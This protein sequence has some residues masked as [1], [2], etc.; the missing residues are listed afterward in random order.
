MKLEEELARLNAVPLNHG[1]P[2]LSAPVDAAMDTASVE[3]AIAPFRLPSDLR[4]LWEQVDLEQIPNAP[5]RIAG[6]PGGESVK[7]QDESGEMQVWCPAATQ[8]SI[9]EQLE[10]DLTLRAIADVASD[11]DRKTLERIEDNLT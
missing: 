1:E 7:V 4:S 5:A 6:T 9:R 2:S 11:P 10:F 8:Q 3:E